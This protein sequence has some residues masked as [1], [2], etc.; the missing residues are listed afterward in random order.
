M[1]RA[2]RKFVNWNFTGR[3]FVEI[4]DG[5]I[6]VLTLLAW[7]DILTHVIAG[8]YFHGVPTLSHIQ[9]NLCSFPNTPIMITPFPTIV[10][11]LRAN[12]RGHIV[13]PCKFELCA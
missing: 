4:F 1:V 3:A 6:M 8:T 5:A 12:G 9:T 2:P 11:V 13:R 7:V 10:G